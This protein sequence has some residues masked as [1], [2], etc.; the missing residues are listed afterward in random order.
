[1]KQQSPYNALVIVGLWN[2][3]I[4]NLDWVS[5]YLLPNT[6]LNVEIP[7]NTFASM[8][9]S[10]DEL[11]IFV[12]DGRL[13]LQVLKQSDEVLEK[14]E[15]IAIQIAEYLPHTPV[16]AFG[17]NY[18]FEENHS[19]RIERLFKFEDS[20]ALKANLG[21]AETSIITRSL[22]DGDF[23]LNFV[24]TKNAINYTFN[25]NYHCMINSIVDFKSQF[26]PK[27]LVEFR[28]KSIKTLTDLYKIE[29]S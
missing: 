3:A 23:T 2:H 8:K 15:E 24:I 21:E 17:I 22:K 29:L 13:N 10:T 6:N 18:V 9:I 19:E 14:I 20:E 25:F 27:I 12:L 26:D 16:T 11:S 28:K 7:L 5:K 1:M 4:F